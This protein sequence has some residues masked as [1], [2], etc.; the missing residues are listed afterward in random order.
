[1]AL[2]NTK[3]FGRFTSSKIVALTKSGKFEHGF[4]APAM[5]YIKEKQIELKMGS[6]LDGGNGYS[7]PIA[8][9]NFMEVIACHKLNSIGKDE[10]IFKTDAT[11]KHPNEYLGDYWSGSSDFLGNTNGKLTFISE[12][13]CY[14]KKK[15]ALYSECINMNDVDLLKKQFPQEYWQIVSNCILHNVDVGEAVVYMPYE[16]DYDMI[17]EMANNYEASDLWKYRFI[18][19]DPMYLLPFIKNGGY[20]KDLNIF[21]FEIPKEDKEFLTERVENAI[22]LLI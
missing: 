3:R 22:L 1:M 7:K 13:K 20:Y 11:I 12:L 10:Y 2:D 17:V 14:Q 6:T 15:F 16:S 5:T 4:G 18:T 21:R 19:E 9:G 8:W